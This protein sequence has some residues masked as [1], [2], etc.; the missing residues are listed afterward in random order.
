MVKDK[1]NKKDKGKEMKTKKA[2]IVILVILL[3]GLV[4]CVGES[5]NLKVENQQLRAK[6]ET[7]DVFIIE[8]ENVIEPKR[9]A[10]FNGT[11]ED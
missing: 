4:G 5:D 6:I 2:M 3:L 10:I 11:R 7:L 1:E 8:D 9:I